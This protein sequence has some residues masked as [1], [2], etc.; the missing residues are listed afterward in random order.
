MIESLILDID[1]KNPSREQMLS[2]IK[3][4]N[5]RIRP[6][7]GDIFILAAKHNHLL[8]SLWKLSKIE[9]VVIRAA[10]TLDEGQRSIFF[11]YIDSFENRMQRYILESMEKLSKTE[12]LSLKTMT[13]EVSREA[14]KGKGNIN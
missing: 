1:Q 9:E 14:K 12:Q 2:D 11:G 10:D 6:V 4:M 7:G 3:Q 8:K 5:Y 13:L